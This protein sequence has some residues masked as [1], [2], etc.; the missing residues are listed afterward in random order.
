MPSTITR[1]FAYSSLILVTA[2]TSL[3]AARQQPDATRAAAQPVKQLKTTDWIHPSTEHPNGYDIDFP[4]GTLADYYRCIS[5]QPGADKLPPLVVSE[6][7]DQVRVQAVALRGASLWSLYELPARLIPGVVVSGMGDLA[8]S[9]KPGEAPFRSSL[10]VGVDPSLAKTVVR[11]ATFDL[12]FRGGTIASYAQAIR[13][14]CPKANIVVLGDAAEVP[15]PAMSLRDVTV[16]ASMRAVEG[17]QQDTSGA[18][19]ALFVRGV[20]IS[21]SPESVYTIQRAPKHAPPEERPSVHV[22]SLSPSLASGAKLADIL[23]AIEAA[24]AVDGRPSKLSYHEAT[25]L[26]IVRGVETQH[27]LVDSVIHEVEYSK[28]VKDGEKGGSRE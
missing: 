9:A 24:L 10:V 23:S 8:A 11:P 5:A 22:W 7:A 13:E 2:A 1:R 19:T 20:D 3:A 12:D 25:N 6:A 26:L 17:Q 21:G 16:E 14:A 15:L 18:E 27:Q 4:G 28:Q